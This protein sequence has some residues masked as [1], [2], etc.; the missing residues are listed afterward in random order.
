MTQA[1]QQAVGKVV[2]EFTDDRAMLAFLTNEAEQ[3]KL[4]AEYPVA[5]FT[6]SLDMVSRKVYVVRRKVRA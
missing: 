2:R 3:E 4:K 5:D 1:Q 6:A